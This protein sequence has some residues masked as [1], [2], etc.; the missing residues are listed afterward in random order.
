MVANALHRIS[1]Y[2]KNL[3]ILEIDRFS[4]TQASTLKGIDA[5][6]SHAVVR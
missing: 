1:L 2:T 3:L 6:T 4:F 5:F